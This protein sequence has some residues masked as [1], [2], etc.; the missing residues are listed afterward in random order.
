MG[1]APGLDRALLIM[2]MIMLSACTV[3][4]FSIFAYFLAY[5]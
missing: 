1:S 3:C 5:F 4:L 2:I